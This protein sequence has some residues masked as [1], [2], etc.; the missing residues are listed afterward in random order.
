MNENFYEFARECGFARRTRNGLWEFIIPPGAVAFK[1][2]GAKSWKVYRHELSVPAEFNIL[3]E[4]LCGSNLFF[5]SMRDLCYVL[6]RPYSSRLAGQL[7]KQVR[8]FGFRTRKLSYFYDR[9]KRIRDCVMAFDADLV[10]LSPSDMRQKY[11][12]EAP[13][14]IATLQRFRSSTQSQ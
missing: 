10:R 8:R 13:E 5:W 2:K 4:M 11:L 1:G 7:G 3:R 6:N 12:E 9:T 14:R